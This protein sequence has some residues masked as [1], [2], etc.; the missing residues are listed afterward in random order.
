MFN[1]DAI[2]HTMFSLVD[3]S[4]LALVATARVSC[5]EDSDC[6]TTTPS[7]IRG[8]LTHALISPIVNR[9]WDTVI[10]W[11]AFH[12]DQV[13]SLLDNEG[14]SALHQ[15]CLFMAPAHV[16]EALLYASPESA[17]V[18]SIHGELPLHWAVR[19]SAPDHVL[20]LLLSA[21]P[22]GG[23]V[24]DRAGRTPVSIIWDRHEK[25]LSGMCVDAGLSAD[26]LK[27]LNRKL[28][29]G[30]G[31]RKMML[32]LRAAYNGTVTP[33]PPGGREFRPIHAVAGTDCPISLLQTILRLHESRVRETDERGM[34]PLAVAVESH[35]FD[36]LYSGA[37][38]A[39]ILRYY[40]EAASVP[41]PVDGRLPLVSA[42][43]SGKTWDGGVRMLFNAE[44]WVISNRDRVS[45]LYPFMLAAVNLD[46]ES[47]QN[48]VETLHSFVSFRKEEDVLNTIF[49]LL[50]A[51]PERVRPLEPT[52]CKIQP[53][54]AF[55]S[56]PES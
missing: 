20:C 39:E 6:I 3:E 23:L 27:S 40:P 54:V 56:M 43:S 25:N 5:I 18:A 45:G 36:P 10:S 30:S 51:D 8:G 41:H 46:Q 32:L 9:E 34:T 52:S 7:H 33:E 14:Q 38:I 31:W 4:E 26:V 19:L 55:S 13:S 48:K 17:S 1:K 42:I 21:N 2:T 44:P 53:T 22:F 28:T 11:A 12:P 35:V 29:K 49:Q 47:M 37:V 16:V 50:L 24:P 15:A